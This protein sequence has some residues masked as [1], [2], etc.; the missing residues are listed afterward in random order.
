MID[1]LYYFIQENLVIFGVVACMMLMEYCKN[2]RRFLTT[3]DHYFL[4]GIFTLWFARVL[5]QMP[6]G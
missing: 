3:P 5:E 1:H 6:R 2:K 4:F